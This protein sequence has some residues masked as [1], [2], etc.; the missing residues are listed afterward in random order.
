MVM[1]L[2]PQ[3]RPL[4]PPDMTEQNE[5][6]ER[7]QQYAEGS[8]GCK[9]PITAVAPQGQPANN[10]YDDGDDQDEPHVES[11]FRGR[12][13]AA[14]VGRRCA[15]RDRSLNE[16]DRVSSGFKQTRCASDL[17]G[18]DRDLRHSLIRCFNSEWPT[19]RW[20]VLFDQ[21]S[22]EENASPRWRS[23][24]FAAA[25]RRRTKPESS[26]EAC[27]CQRVDL[28]RTSTRWSRRVRASPKGPMFT[29]A[30]GAPAAI[31]ASRI[32]APRTLARF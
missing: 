26:T 31:S 16:R 5:H 10:E 1:D 15:A 6:D 8:A 22:L 17:V 29:W 24:G 27:P 32:A 21:G 13:A 11:P 9:A 4:L 14:K 23:P 12:V 28:S 25:C 20:L 18:E 2:A 3:A 19:C 30:A 7:S